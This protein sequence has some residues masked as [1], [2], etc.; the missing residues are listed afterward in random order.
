MKNNWKLST[1][2]QDQE[3]NSD[4]IFPHLEQIVEH[5]L[6]ARGIDSEVS[7]RQ[8]FSPDYEGDLC[9]P[10]LMGDMEKAVQRMLKALEQKQRVCVFGDY[11]ADGVTSS[12][13]L[14]D[15]FQQVGLENFCYIPDRNKEGYGLNRKAIDY[16][17][18]KKADLI[19]TVD[20]G[21]S[22]APEVEYAKQLKI[23]VIV[24][25]HH[26]VPKT[27]PAAVAV[28]NPQKPDDGYPHKSLAGVGVA[29]KFVQALASR[30]EDYDPRQLRWLLDL[31]A[32]GTIADCV[33]LLGENRTLTKYGLIVL[34]KT[35]RVGLKQLFQVGRVNISEHSLP[36]SH[37]IAFQVAPRINAAG[38]MDHANTAYQLLISQSDQ[39]AAAR[40]LALE[41]ESQNQHRQKVTKLIVDEA[42]KRTRNKTEIPK[43]IVET[44]EHWEMGVIG[45]A[46]GKITDIFNRPAILLQKTETSFRGSGRSIKSST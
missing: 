9:D 1:L 17:K 12:A 23:D 11:D 29:F 32:I 15:F 45:L 46:A 30:I 19:L 14:K 28:V 36:T 43:I 16:I 4:R 5:I 26:H 44:D 2:I 6:R 22:N 38:R 27:V 41:L 35:R 10:F 3:N 21:I 37:Q 24:L 31:V 7:M 42:E 34:S 18:E 39:D 13:L 8:F 25:D 20:C 40:I 33:P